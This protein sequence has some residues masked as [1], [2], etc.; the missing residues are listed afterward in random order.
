[1]TGADLPAHRA[2]LEQEQSEEH[3]LRPLAR[4]LLVHALH[5]HAAPT[6]QT[7]PGKGQPGRTPTSMRRPR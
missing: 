1:M 4:A 2:Q 7:K 3:D 5:V 6:T